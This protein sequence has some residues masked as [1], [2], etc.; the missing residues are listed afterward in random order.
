MS[1]TV[2]PDLLEAARAIGPIIREHAEEAERQRRLSPAVIQA[3]A[4]AGFLG[5]YVPRSL[6]GLEVDP[7]TCARVV[8][9]VSEFDSAAGWSIMVANAVAWWC[10]RLPAEGSEELYAE[11]P[12]AII[13]TAFHPPVQAAEVPGGY[14]LT[15]RAPLASNVHDASWLLLTALIM[16]GDQPRMADG[17]PEVIGAIFRVREAEIID[18]WHSL[19]MRG[20]DSNDVAVTDVFVPVSRTFRFLPA[21][22][23]GAHYRGP[24]YRAPALGPALAAWAPVAL[25]IARGAITE[26]YGLAQRKTPFASTTV[27]RERA[28]AQAKVGQAE[29]VLRSARLLLYDA[30]TE[31]WKRTLAGEPSSLEQKADLLMASVHA[32]NSAARSVELMYGAA[33]TSAIYAGCPLERHF[34]DIQVLKQHGFFSESRYE[35]VGQVYLGLPPT[36]GWWRSSRRGRG[37]SIHVKRRK[38]RDRDHRSAHPGADRRRGRAMNLTIE[39]LSTEQEH[40]RD[41]LANRL[42]HTCLTAL[43]I[44]AVYIGDRLGYYAALA[45]LGPTTS[46]ELARRAGTHERYAREWLEQQAV[47]GILVVDDVGADALA[48]RYALEPG[49]AEVLLDRDSLSYLIPLIRYY[50]GTVPILPAVIDAYRTGRGVSWTEMGRELVEAQADFNRALYA[51]FLGTRDLPSMPDVDAR[52]NADPPARVADIGCGAG[53]SSIALSRAYPKALVH[54]LDSDRLA[55]QIA[56]RNASE[57]GVSDRVTFE[58][59]D[60][61]DLPRGSFDLVLLLECLHDMAHPVAVLRGVRDLLA[62]GGAVIV[63]DERVADAFT[64]P[65]DDI[66]RMMYGWSLVQCLPGGMAE[67]GSAGTGAVMR[68][69]TLQRYAQEAGFSAVQTLPIDNDPLRRWYRLIP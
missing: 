60:A 61:A 50:L 23:P 2:A 19:G 51:R 56:R 9:E 37:V 65:G 39:A 45:E 63:M 27:L 31:A 36:W 5:M 8:E 7:V 68:A 29:A 6:G 41:E 30:L 42:F 46:T 59:R 47:S 34:R 69:S 10:A 67:E 43:D 25:A 26:F 4:E 21:F 64:A 44:F 32:M 38:H 24:L 55:I 40:K 57:A 16:D 54:G 15:G 17:A 11:T 12:D 13:A 58:V 1:L 48:R 14:R 53:W 22:E 3:L 52:L 66:E 35:T 28:S 33:G 62:P 20:T 18:T 49:H